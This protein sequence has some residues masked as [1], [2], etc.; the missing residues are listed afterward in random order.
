[1]QV[2]RVAWLELAMGTGFAETGEGAKATDL[3]ES[4]VA[5]VR[6]MHVAGP[7]QPELLAVILDVASHCHLR[8]KDVKRAL[9][10]STEA[11]KI[12]EDPAVELWGNS[13]VAILTGMARVRRAQKKKK[14]ALELFKRAALTATLKARDSPR[15]VA[16]SQV[17]LYLYLLELGRKAEAEKMK[18]HVHQLVEEAGFP[19]GNRIRERLR[20]G[21][22]EG[23]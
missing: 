8:N 14:E 12:L 20:D 16:Y 21:K 9:V 7:A 17:Y 22:F 18:E 1:M 15:E 5:R 2:D 6:A 19:K 3:A 4:A 23:Y 10:V 11:M 13:Q